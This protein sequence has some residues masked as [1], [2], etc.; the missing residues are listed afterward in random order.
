MHVKINATWGRELASEFQKPY[1]INLTE[2]I[3]EAYRNHRVFPPGSQILR[4]FDSCPFDR[5]KVVILGQDPYHGLGQAEGLAF[6]VPEGVTPPPSLKNILREVREDVGSTI[7]EGGNLLPWVK[8]GI[9]LLNSTLTVEEGKPNSHQA[10][11]WET[12]TDAALE[13]LARERENI[14]FLLW[15]AFARRKKDLIPPGKHL[16]LE[17]PH[18]SPLSASRGFLG[19][20]HFSK[21]NAYLIEKGLEPIVW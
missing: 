13:R 6:S 15:G 18:P 12:F 17:A 2:K 16:I 8:Q 11:G 21:T 4:A 10:Y 9:L 5:V 19:C 20:R 14:V 7:I 3:R 1:F